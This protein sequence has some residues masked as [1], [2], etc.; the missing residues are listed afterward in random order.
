[1]RF[2]PSGYIL[3]FPWLF[4]ALA[5]LLIG[6]SS[7]ESTTMIAHQISRAAILI[8]AF[9]SA[10]G[11]MFFSLNFGEEA[12][13]SILNEI[14]FY[15]L[16]ACLSDIVLDINSL[17]GSATSAWVH[18]SL[19]VQSLQQ[20]WVALLWF[21]GQ[22]LNTTDPSLYHPPAWLAAVVWPASTVCALSGLLLYAGLP[23]YCELYLPVKVLLATTN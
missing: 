12:V 6:I 15:H 1:M 13:S 18:R 9:G 17:Q 11:F 5:F 4:F 14:Y 8:Y 10:A 7:F 22:S 3:V 23:S 2:A 19:I 16:P 20:V 21:W